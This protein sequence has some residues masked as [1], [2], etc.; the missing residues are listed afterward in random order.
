MLQR[1][2]KKIGNGLY[3]TAAQDSTETG[4]RVPPSITEGRH[5]FWIVTLAAIASLAGAT[6][7]ASVRAIIQRSVEANNRDWQAAPEYSYCERDRTPGGTR[8]YSVTMILGSPYRRLVAVNGKPLPRGQ[9]AAE[10]SKLDE[11]IARRRSESPGERARRIAQ[12]RNDRQRDHELI[13]QLAVAFDFRLLGL[14]KLGP[15][16]VYLLQASPR[17]GYKPPNC[18]STVLAGMQGKLWVDANTFQ[19]V[20]VE[21]EVVHPVWIEGF[22]ARVEPGTRFAL[23]YT[24]LTSGVWLPSRYVMRS[25]AKVLLLFSR[26]DQADESY[27]GYQ[28]A[29]AHGAHG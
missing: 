10:Q 2:A 18:D 15:R 28:K 6:S 24:P 21:A 22:V 5:I 12:Y 14:R 20:K 29:A 1:T 4:N 25:R 16:E 13:G 3:F 26:R 8:A 19:W 11:T 17:P 27:F 9:Q 7:P 23:E